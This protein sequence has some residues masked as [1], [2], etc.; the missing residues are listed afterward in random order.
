MAKRKRGLGGNLEDHKRLRDIYGEDATKYLIGAKSDASRGACEDALSKLVWAAL[1][2]GRLD[3]ESS[4]VATAGGPRRSKA[5]A[6][7]WAQHEAAE[8][9]FKR[10]C[11]VR[12][13]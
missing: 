11:V 1:A 13:K 12:S 8:A 5:L 9:A 10:H 6:K 3:A 7:S 4:W 2:R